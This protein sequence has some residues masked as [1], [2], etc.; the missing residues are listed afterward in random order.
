MAGAAALAG[1]SSS[2][3]PQK[4]QPA[5]DTTAAKEAPPPQQAAP[6]AFQ[7]HAPATFNVTFDTTNG[8]VVVEVHR[9]WAPIGADHFY[10]LVKAGYFDGC[11]FFRV[12]PNFIV[13]FGIAA[14]PAVTRKWKEPPLA[15]DPVLRHNLRGTLVYATAGPNTRTTQL[16]INLVD[17]TRSLDPQGFAPFGA[18]TSGMDAV[19]AI[20][21]G[22][23]EA[24]QQP[25]IESQGNAY[26]QPQFP[27]L[28]Y[29]RKATIQ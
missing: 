19:D 14:D 6:A 27:K 23:G 5:A 20:Y 21:P 15:D 9:D 13:Q 28:D 22:Y 2:S 10:E 8:A 12:V 24:P 4:E 1:C 3:E 25:L 16:F 17:N 18:V 29:I 26:L 11:R 7:V